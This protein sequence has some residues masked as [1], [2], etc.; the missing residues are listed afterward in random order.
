MSLHTRSQKHSQAAYPRVAARQKTGFDE[1]STVAR[2]FPALI[3]TCGL[4]QAVAFAQAKRKKDKLDGGA[5]GQYLADLA[6]VLRAGGHPEIKT[7]D[8]LAKISREA[9]VSA[10]LRLSRNAI[11]AAVW[12]KRYAEAFAADTPAAG[13]ANQAPS[14]GEPTH[15]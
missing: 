15:A 9:A 7:A 8:D 10:Y 1:Y 13:A 4:A 14:S 11:E 2:K 3:H 5:E 12:L 6:E